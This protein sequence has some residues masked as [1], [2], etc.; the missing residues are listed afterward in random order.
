MC[1][2][3]AT[4]A[5]L[6]VIGRHTSDGE[7]E[8][9]AGGLVA[10]LVGREREFSTI[11][12]AW[13]TAR[14]AHGMRLHVL[15]PPGL[16]KT[17]LLQD[18]G[19]R[20]RAGGAR[21]VQ[22]RAHPGERHLPFG[23]AT[24]LAT[25]LA[26]HPGARAI[27]PASASALL[28]LSPALSSTFTAPPDHAAGHDALRRRA[29]ALTELIDAV[30]DE[31]PVAILVDDLHWA[32]PDSRHLLDLVLPRIGD[33][34]ALVLTTTRPIPG[35]GTTPADTIELAPLTA[36]QI[37][38]LAASI[39]A[40]ADASLGAALPQLLLQATAGSPLLVLET[41]QTAMERGLL[42]I[43]DDTWTCTHLAEL[44]AQLTAGSAL[45]A[46]VEGLARSDR[47]LLTLLAAAGLPLSEYLL[48]GATGWE[49]DVVR[50]RLVELERRGFATRGSSGWLPSHDE[51]ADQ[52]WQTAPSAGRA[53]AQLAIGTAM[54]EAAGTVASL[55]PPAAQLLQSS[56]D[57][58]ALYA[59]AHRWVRLRR[60]AGDYRHAHTLV[61]ELLGGA[62]P[63]LVATLPLRDRLGAPR[64]AA[65][66]AAAILVGA[67]GAMLA[68]GAMRRP[69]SEETLVLFGRSPDGGATQFAV[70]VG[71][72]SW[73]AGD[74]LSVASASVPILPEPA[75]VHGTTIVPSPDGGVV[76]FSRVS[77]DAGEIDVYVRDARGRER[78]LTSAVGDDKPLGWSPDGR[79]LL[80]SS[81]RW[82]PGGGY[83]LASID[84]TDGT[85]TRLTTTATNET[86][87]VW[88]PDGTRIALSRQASDASAGEM[89][90]MD[91]D[92]SHENCTTSTGEGN[93]YPITWGGDSELLLLREMVGAAR[94][95]VLDLR[96]RRVTALA[97][98][99]QQYVYPSPGGDWIACDCPAG[100]A[101]RWAWVAFPAREPALRR[102][103][104][105]PW[106]SPELLRAAWIPRREQ[107]GYLDTI[108]IDAPDQ[109]LRVGV[110]H[111]LTARGRSAS[112]RE[113]VP[114]S[115]RWWVSDT[116][117]A[118]ITD[119]SFLL[120]LRPGRIVVHATAG[121]WRR[122][123]W[124][125]TLQSLSLP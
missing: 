36:T 47:W 59:F 122:T 114:A 7:P 109:P 76:A 124:R 20:L 67:V 119:R 26:R 41:L 10:E 98:A 88:S 18:T 54:G 40:F 70:E 102:P 92:G 30:A 66:A 85:T 118:Q 21:I 5:L 29:I 94:L 111:L 52:A 69:H 17:R 121:G 105:V 3:P 115:L 106:N 116:A 14:A 27:S 15:A 6:R 113:V 71:R 99:A 58:Q 53:A 39:A 46:R 28:S 22:V 45:R 80:A 81:G 120:A 16:G 48:A 42:G 110:R 1:P 2:D 96:T 65:L 123:H 97:D 83:E 95:E 73:M 55:A 79:V 78:R 38:A 57:R 51:I 101:G 90:V 43:E 86:R 63:T 61:A 56:G 100:D 19:A 112:G 103:L 25:A 82:Q 107:L 34:R 44:E 23:L 60:R 117:T 64:L 93:A 84:I 31:G 13:E 108:E 9:T 8:T 104:Q 24:E 125:S 62:D 32:D 49:P 50:E 72:S 87:A 68:I 4:R 74:P 37:G 75:T 33:C 91:A 35:T 77:H 89:C 12:T 11:I